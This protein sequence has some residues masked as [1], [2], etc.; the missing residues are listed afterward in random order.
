MASHSIYLDE[1]V[2]RSLK[3]RGLNVSRLCR[4]HLAVV[5]GANIENDTEKSEKFKALAIKNAEE[6][7][8]AKEEHEKQLSILYK[9]HEEE[10]K[11][12]EDRTAILI[13]QFEK[14]IAAL[15]ARINE[16]R[17]EK[18]TPGPPKKEKTRQSR[19]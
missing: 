16:L 1:D 14:E 8:R 5:A 10:K 17:K 13:S 6:L 18:S 3:R 12:I 11:K 2:F 7:A 9:R 15:K 19:K 4:Q